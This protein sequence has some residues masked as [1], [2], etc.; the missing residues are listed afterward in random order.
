MAKRIVRTLTTLD[1][2]YISVPEFALHL[3]VGRELV[4]KWIHAEAL[5]AV[6]IG[7]LWRIHA[8]DAAAF[9]RKNRFSPRKHTS[10]ACE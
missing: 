2:A 8:H 9:I 3:R 6:K 7:H 1:T 5:P 4:M 10:G